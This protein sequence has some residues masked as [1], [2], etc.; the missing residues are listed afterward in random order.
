MHFR[1][2]AT[3]RH[4]MKL[5]RAYASSAANH[6][7]HTYCAALEASRSAAIFSCNPNLQEGS[8]VVVTLHIPGRCNRYAGSLG[9]PH[10]QLPGCA[11]VPRSCWPTLKVHDIAQLHTNNSMSNG[12]LNLGNVSTNSNM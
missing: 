1:H 3:I 7:P 12:L 2:F 10:G 6:F 4:G 11:L 5:W 9:S 8:T